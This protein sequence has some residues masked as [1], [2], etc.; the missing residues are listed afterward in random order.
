M[1]APPTD[2]STATASERS[3]ATRTATG[4]VGSPSRVTSSSASRA[5]HARL[6]AILIVATV[7]RCL[8]L[9]ADAP[10][11]VSRDFSLSTDA[12]WYGAA[13]LDASVG[14]EG[15][16][17]AAYD[18]PLFTAYLRAVLSIGGPTFAALNAA[19]IPFGL[20]A[21]LFTGLTARRLYGDTAGLLA[22][23]FLGW[24]HAFL[25][26]NRVAMPY[27]A[28]T[29]VLAV[30]VFLTSSP[31][32]RWWHLPVAALF[33]V[34]GVLTLKEILVLSAPLFVVRP[35]TLTLLR[36]RPAL[37]ATAL[38]ATIACVCGIGFGT[39]LFTS[40][41][42]K[43]NDYFAANSGPGV[44]ERLFRFESRSGIFQALP[45]VL[46]LAL[47]AP[48]T[49]R[50]THREIPIFAFLLCGLAAFVLA[51]YS[52]LRYLLILSTLR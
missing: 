36:R 16:A 52:P 9:D 21:I 49:R 42:Q 13:A 26:F 40:I 47:L 17:S 34:G 30:V 41:A 6:V 23:L 46:P 14:R 19:S 43:W 20:L 4:A 1:S 22:A 3:N 15:D 37:A 29:A 2:E 25:V 45:F 7:I 35:S 18:K 11:D 24:S 8:S 10:L 12:S 28:L 48:L 44:F 33:C 5:F 32:P 51:A 50:L 39:G 38:I 27:S 31:R